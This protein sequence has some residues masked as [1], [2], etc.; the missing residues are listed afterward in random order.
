MIALIILSI[1]I[2][3]SWLRVGRPSRRSLSGAILLDTGIPLL[4]RI[5][6]HLVT[7]TMVVAASLALVEF[8]DLPWWGPLVAMGSNV[9]LIGLPIRYRLTTNGIRVG[10]TPFRRWTEFAGVA[11]APGGARLQAVAGSRDKRIWLSGSRGEDEFLQL[12]RQMI[13]SAYQG[14]NVLID[15]PPKSEQSPGKSAASTDITSTAM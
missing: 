5:R 9:G 2:V 7:C 1:F 3:L 4:A 12:L 15:F 14:R 6:M 13:K 11:R 8:M 10:W